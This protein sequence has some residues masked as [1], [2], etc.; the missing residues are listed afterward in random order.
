MIRRLLPVWGLLVLAGLLVPT[1]GA[2]QCLAPVFGTPI[3]A[4]NFIIVNWDAVPAASGGYVLSWRLYN[5]P[6]ATPVTTISLAGTSYMLTGLMAG[7]PY[8]IKLTAVCGSI[9]STTTTTIVNTLAPPPPPPPCLSPSLIGF[10]VGDTQLQLNWS[11]APSGTVEGYRIEYRTGA[12]P[13]ETLDLTGNVLTGTLSGLLPNTLYEV[14]VRTR[15]AG[16][17]LSNPGQSSFIRTAPVPCPAPQLNFPIATTNSLFVSW[18]PLPQATTGYRLEYRA[19]GAPTWQVQDADPNTSS[20]L[21]SNLLGGTTYELRLQARCSSTLTS[22]F[23]PVI[24]ATTVGQSCPAPNITAAVPAQNQIALSWTPIPAAALG[25]RIEF[26]TGSSAWSGFDVGPSPTSTTISSLQAGTTYEVRVQSRCSA[27]TSSAFTTTTATTTSAC[28]VPVLLGADATP[29]SLNVRWLPQPAATGYRL[30]WRLA[31]GGPT[32]TQQLSAG[33]TQFNIG[34]LL[35]ATA[36]LVELQSLCNAIPSVAA[37]QTFTTQN[38]AGCPAPIIRRVEPTASTLLVFFGG[39]NVP[40]LG[41]RL[42]YRPTATPNLSWVGLDLPAAPTLDPNQENTGLIAGLLPNTSYDIR[43]RTRCIDNSVSGWE[44]RT[45]QTLPNSCPA[46]VLQNVQ[47][48]FSAINL[49]WTGPQNQ[50]FVLEY[51]IQYRELPSGTPQFLFVPPFQTF[52]TLTQNVFPGR[53]YEI[54]LQTACSIIDLSAAATRTVRTQGLPCAAPSTPVV[55]SGVRTAQ[56]S[57]TVPAG[58]PAASYTL[59]Y[60]RL[61]DSNW[62]LRQV[63]GTSAS[64]DGLQPETMYELRVRTNCSGGSFSEFN[65]T[66]FQTQPV[67]C[68]APQPVLGERTTSSLALSWPVVPDANQYELEWRSGASSWNGIVLNGTAFTISGLVA[69]TDYE[70]RVRS[71]CPGPAGNR[72]S[73]FSTLTGRTL[74]PPCPSVQL[75]SVV[76]LTNSIQL[77]W[78]PVPDAFSG[79]RLR[80]KRASDT[81]FLQLD[82]PFVI[83]NF[84]IFNLLANTAYNIEIQSLCGPGRTSEATQRTVTTLAAFC[85]VPAI[86]AVEP[87]NESILLFWSQVPA[88]ASG[89]VVS[90][91]LAGGTFQETVV[92]AAETSFRISGLQPNQ[93]YELRLRSRC[94][95]TSISEWSPLFPTSTTNVCFSPSFVDLLPEPFALTADWGAVSGAQGYRVSWGLPGQPPI[96][97]ADVAGTL[98]RFRIENLSPDTEYEVQVRTRCLGN[99]FS[100][101]N[102]GF[103]F[104]GRDVCIPPTGLTLTPG[105]DRITAT[106]NFVVAADGGYLVEWRPSGGSWRSVILNQNLLTIENLL[107]G[108][109]YEVRVFSRCGNRSSGLPILATTIT[110]TANACPSPTINLISPLVNGAQ[111]SWTPVA[112]AVLGYVVEW[113][114]FDAAGWQ[115][116]TVPANQTSASLG[117]LSPQTSY[118]V[119]VRSRCAPN[120]ESAPSTVREFV[121]LNASD[122]PAP[123]LTNFNATPTSVNVQWTPVNGAIG[124]RIEFAPVNNPAALRVIERQ[125]PLANLLVQGLLPG[126]EYRFRVS[127]HCRTQ[128]SAP[129][130]ERIIAT[131]QARATYEAAALDGWQL[132][133][134]PNRGA[135]VLRFEAPAAGQTQF[136]LF[137]LAGR[138]V[139]RRSDSFAA[140]QVELHLD[141]G[142]LP[143]GLYLLRRLDAPNVPALRVVVE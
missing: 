70:I 5:P 122:C 71:I 58:T 97:Q 38:V 142:P 72:F 87:E 75:S 88:A 29:N 24:T 74:D 137:D 30:S 125:Q 54:I 96:G 55:A 140:G 133:P 15:C 66:T 73:S 104:T 11:A 108:T 10:Q 51:R 131:P 6:F 93:N 129:S 62:T 17:V 85:P 16:N 89:Y 20:L 141:F 134:N 127:T 94:T 115:S 107:P 7:T 46:P 123:T 40:H 119:R 67:P 81:N 90:W 86:Q 8:E 105:I 100:E 69:S 136:A 102:F 120:D 2:A 80:W 109:A 82:L 26:R 132:Y 60:R 98:T 111:V 32:A 21:L 118:R 4:T 27:A 112:T 79:Y 50:V 101:P 99:T 84:E 28:P 18:P 42:E 124:Y 114:T 110:P 117:G 35:P 95:A 91:R 64:L 103:E 45:A 36:Y 77:A 12:S 13:F 56:V 23:S 22:A 135:F 48:G 3:S 9:T 130:A 143:G 68:L 116:M 92:G 41:Y 37:S 113:Q 121:T 83:T 139:G 106:W 25:Y 126:T 63:S 138:E 57:W 76:P 44:T 31:S 61:N 19:L 43:I 59:E 128:T 14:R 1:S 39:S 34:G 53:E 47:A 52:A 49:S 65:L 33:T 78:I